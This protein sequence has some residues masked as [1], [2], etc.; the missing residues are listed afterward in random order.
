MRDRHPRVRDA[1][2]TTGKE[3]T[4]TRTLLVVPIETAGHGHRG[5]PAA[6]RALHPDQNQAA[7]SPRWAEGS[8]FDGLTRTRVGSPTRH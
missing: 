3:K 1:G 8:H 4:R 2:R 7:G 5:R 6:D